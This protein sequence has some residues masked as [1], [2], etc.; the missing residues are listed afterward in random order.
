[1]FAKAFKAFDHAMLGK[2]TDF[3]AEGGL[4]LEDKP[5]EL[6]AEETGAVYGGYL[7]YIYMFTAQKVGDDEFLPIELH[8]FDAAGG[9]IDKNGTAEPYD[10]IL[11]PLGVKG[12]G[13]KDRM[14]GAI[15]E[16][17]EPEEYK[18]IFVEKGKG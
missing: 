16:A 13:G 7:G 15:T 1:M 5:D 3:A 17:Y 18:N 11:Q 8:L 12:F 4:F 9:K 6:G 14:A 10:G 2:K